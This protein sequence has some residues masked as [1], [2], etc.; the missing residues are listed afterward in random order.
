MLVSVSGE[1]KNIL[2]AAKFCVKKNINLITLS[3]F[4]NDNS[5]MKINNKGL[6]FYIKTNSY[7]I[8]EISHL[9]ILL[10]SVDLTKNNMFYKSNIGKIK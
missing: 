4:K 5:L 3:S 2:S 6:N 8:A 9:I 10:L 1:S 7:N